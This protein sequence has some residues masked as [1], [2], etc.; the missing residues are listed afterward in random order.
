[1]SALSGSLSYARF[2]VSRPGHEGEPLPRGFLDDS[3]EKVLH[4]AMR[5]LDPDEVADAEAAAAE[6]AAG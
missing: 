1:M 3:Y 2:F 4:H 6:R 5:P